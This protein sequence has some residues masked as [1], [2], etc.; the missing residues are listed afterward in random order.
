MAQHY[1]HLAKNDLPQNPQQIHGIVS[2]L[3]TA[4]QQLP[5]EEY[6]EIQ[7][8]WSQLS[9]QA[10]L[11]ETSHSDVSPQLLPVTMPEQGIF[12]LRFDPTKSL[13]IAEGKRGQKVT[14]TNEGE[15]TTWLSSRLPSNA[16]ILAVRYEGRME[17]SRFRGHVWNATINI[18]A[19][20]DSY[21]VPGCSR[22]FGFGL[23]TPSTENLIL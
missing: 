10:L 7:Q 15:A 17:I 12:T 5:Q 14:I 23:L 21:H 20:Q 13:P 4:G 9:P 3:I 19:P 8:S 11:I 18:E 6:N 1:L 16:A 2:S 22:P